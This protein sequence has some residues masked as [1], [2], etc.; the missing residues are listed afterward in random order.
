MEGWQ[1]QIA[2]E[3][4]LEV[5][6]PCQ[7]SVVLPAY[8]ERRA[9]QQVLAELVSVLSQEPVE[10][11]ILVVDDGSTDGTGELAEQFAHSC[12]DCP[13]RIIRCPQ[14]RGA[15]AARKVGIRQAR[16]QIV[17]MLDADGTYP[18]EAI[19]SLLQHFPAYDQVNGAR[20]SEQGSWPWLRRPAKWFIRKLACYLTGHHIPD[21]NTG[22]KAFKR[23]VMLD[24]LWVVPDGFSCVTTMTLAFLTNGH[25][26]KYVPIQYRPRIGRS[27][28][29]P[30]QDSLSYLATV[31]RMVL[32]FR[33]L[34][35][36]LP[37]A[38]VVIAGGVL[39]SFLS[40]RITGSMQESDV[41][42]L[43]AG[44][45][46]CMFGLLAEVIVAHHRR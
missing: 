13:V 28:F 46:T 37:L 5:G 26:V 34:K 43:T 19:P 7:L 4:A 39:K 20:T 8:N 22:L 2:A 6:S 14:R 35:V 45:L 1:R 11:E 29:R 21:L 17:V 10:Y 33:P 31:L 12:W 40:W 41:V 36:F 15:G 32:Y 38:G 23:D 25:A 9:I 27:K 18:A 3:P 44:F 42:I 30:V 16:G 24:W